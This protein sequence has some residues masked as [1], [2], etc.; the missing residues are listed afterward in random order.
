MNKNYTFK[1]FCWRTIAIHMIAYLIAAVIAQLTFN[2]K[3]L[4]ESETLR[5]IMRP[6]D[7]SLVAL[8]P[9]LQ[10]INGFFMA[11]ILYRIRSLILNEKN[12]WINLFLIIAGF[13]IFAPQAPAPGTF[14]GWIYT[15][16]PIFEHLIGLPE[17][18]LYSF[19]FSFGLY[20][21]YR[22]PKKYW[23]IISI[24]SITIIC[25]ISTLGFL[26]SIGIIKS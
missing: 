18:L 4:F 17:C 7:S 11:L 3:S 26:A 13:S 1:T 14:E 25:I 22:Y 20:K 16:L 8:G 10:C 9:A 6:W 23:N 12:S 24:I 2:Y 21:W 15:K 5:L 19:L